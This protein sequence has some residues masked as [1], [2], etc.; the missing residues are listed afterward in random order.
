MYVAT[1]GVFL[2]FAVWLEV[3]FRV[4]LYQTRR[5]RI[6]VTLIFFVDLLNPELREPV[7]IED[8]IAIV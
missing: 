1:L 4:H 7:F 3:K 8:R 5:E 2:A 6:L